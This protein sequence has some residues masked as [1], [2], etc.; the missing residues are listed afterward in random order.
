MWNYILLI[1]PTTGVF[2]IMCALWLL[3]EAYNVSPGNIARIRLAARLAALLMAL[4]WVSAG[5]FY[6][7]HYGK[8]EQPFIVH[9]PWPWAHDFFMETKEHLFFLTLVLTFFLPFAVKSDLLASRGARNV[10]RATAALVVLSGV[11]IE[12]AGAIISMGAKVAYMDLAAKAATTAAAP[13]AT[14]PA[15]PAA[16]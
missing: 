5:I 16:K 10:V 13:A 12:G 1:H 4:T 2:G 14:T 15:V 6:T 8:A 11:A 7:L 3:V 9:G